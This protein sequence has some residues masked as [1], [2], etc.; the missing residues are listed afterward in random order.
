LIRNWNAGEIISEIQKI[1]FATTDPRMDGY[2]TWACKQDL[3]RV[4]F[5][6]E[7]MLKNCPIYSLED[8]W[9]EEQRLEREKEQI[10]RT[11]NDKKGLE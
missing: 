3:Y 9:L 4:Q 2:T 11:L 1:Y 5:A 7:R 6:L 8:E 10:W